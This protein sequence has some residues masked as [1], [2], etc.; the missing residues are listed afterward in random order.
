MFGNICG[1]RSIHI[2]AFMLMYIHTFRYLR[3][4]DGSGVLAA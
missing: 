1:V 2:E 3:Y 4:I